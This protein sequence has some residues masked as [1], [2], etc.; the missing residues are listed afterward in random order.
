[1]NFRRIWPGSIII[2]RRSGSNLTPAKKSILEGEITDLFTLFEG[3]KGKI[4]L[5]GGV[6]LAL[7]KGK[8]LR[9]YKD[10][11]LAVF[12]KDLSSAT[13]HLKTKKYDLVRRVFLT[14]LGPGWDMEFVL[15]ISLAELNKKNL[16]KQKLRF[17][18]KGAAIRTIR[19]RTAIMDI[20][21]WKEYEDGV[22]APAYQTF[23]PW[24]HVKPYQKFSE[25]SSLLIPDKDNWRYIT[26]KHDFQRTDYNSAG[27]K[28]IEN[29]S[30]RLKRTFFKKVRGIFD[31]KLIIN[32][33][34]GKLKYRQK[35]T[36][37]S[38][39]DELIDLFKGLKCPVYLVGGVG[40]ALSIGSFKRNHKDFD[41]AVFKDD[42]AELTEFLLTSD[43]MLV[44]RSFTMKLSKDLHL[45][46]YTPLKKEQFHLA[47][48][49]KL[50][51]KLLRTGQNRSIYIKQRLDM[52][53]LFIYGKNEYGVL[54]F[55]YNNFI[56]WDDFY[57]AT[58]IS[59]NSALELPNMSQKKYFQPRTET[60]RSDLIRA[61]I[62]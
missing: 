50:V 6:G 17:L 3:M 53:D 24:N 25:K 32:T 35:A 4:F 36:L 26:P 60:E 11:D 61:G 22:Y 30:D 14:H 40:L 47:G 49:T 44:K 15:P 23:M 38:D 10:F 39:L 18:K 2:S 16:L 8:I 28:S 31:S 27:I 59:D 9:N 29:K 55:G 12:D 19:H 52:I 33:K 34:K 56:P 5:I 62:I 1:M 51:V 48:R 13:E 54:H 20:F 41:L 46:I 45:Q 43:Y 58:K 57:P 7:I 21:L 42:L 37:D